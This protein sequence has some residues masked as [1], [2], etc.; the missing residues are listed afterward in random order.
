MVVTLKGVVE[1][2]WKVWSTYVGRCGSQ[3]RTVGLIVRSRVRLVTS[4]SWILAGRLVSHPGLIRLECPLSHWSGG[5][6]HRATVNRWSIQIYEGERSAA[7][8]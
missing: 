8:N 7:L 4:G 1:F 3:I 6:Y 5:R 2:Y